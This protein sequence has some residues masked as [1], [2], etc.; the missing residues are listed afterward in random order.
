MIGDTAEFEIVVLTVSAIVVIAYGLLLLARLKRRG[1]L[2]RILAKSVVDSRTRNTIMWGVGTVA[3]MF[4]LT[5]VLSVLED[6]NLITDDVQNV[7]NSGL[8][9]VGAA[10]LLY[11]TRTGMIL[12]QLN[13]EDELDLRDSH[14]EVFASLERSAAPDFGASSSL[15]QP[16]ALEE[17]QLLELQR[18]AVA[19]S[20]AGANWPTLVP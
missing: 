8:F 17:A 14:P 4:I 10:T 6:V 18:S 12:A 3:G 19:P 9:L 5:G 16:F 1:D 20:G 15:Y 11:L 2:G 13:L 7:V